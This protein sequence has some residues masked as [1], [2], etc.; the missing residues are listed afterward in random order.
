M[1]EV[2]QWACN[3]PWSNGR[4]GLYGFSASAIAVY[5]ALHLELPCVETAVLGAGT[6]EL[7][8]DLLYPG[9]M[10]NLV[11]GLGVLAGIGAPPR[12]T[13]SRGCSATFRSP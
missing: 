1:V 3:Q 8:R 7:Y 6:H 4:L 13:G 9:G 2:L 12:P 11:P 5:N 10:P